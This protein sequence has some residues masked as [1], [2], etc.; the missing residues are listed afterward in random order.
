MKRSILPL[1][2][3]ASSAMIWVGCQTQAQTAQDVSAVA[4]KTADV[5]QETRVLPIATSG[6]LTSKAEVS[7]SFKTP[8][9]IEAIYVDEGTRVRQGQL[10]AKLNLAEINA[11]V[12]QA[13]A[14]FEKAKRDLARVEALYRDSVAT[15]EQQQDAQTAL[16]IAESA[17]EI[18][19][20]NQTH[21]EIR[22]PANGRILRR[23]AEDNE[24]VNPGQP[25]L[26]L[27]SSKEGWVV[28]VGL[29]DRDV[30]KLRLSD[31]ADLHFDAYPTSVFSGRI[32]EIAEAADPMTGTFE[33]EITV[34]DPANALKS[35]FIARV[36]VMPSQQEPFYVIPIE[37]ITEG[38]GK[39]AIIY[40]AEP[41]GDSFTARRHPVRIAHILNDEVAIQSGLENITT[42]ITEG[43]PYLADGALIQIVE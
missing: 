4:V 5:V 37:A 31:Q 8:G 23:L 22:A 42:V 10:L 29:S 43:A 27:G 3:I 9:F 21:S 32:T 18:A 6:R 25:I 33:V 34:E 26:L 24:L 2:L 11:Q 20:F 41:S 16:E 12:Q 35:G 7:L 14:G 30:V 13:Q 15:L 38:N 1:L 40:A 39:D 28:R 36:D 19:T 17:L